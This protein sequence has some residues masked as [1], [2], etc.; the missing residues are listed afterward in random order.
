MSGVTK[1]PKCGKYLCGITV[2]VKEEGT[3]KEL[4]SNPSCT[5][6]KEINLDNLSRINQLEDILRKIIDTRYENDK[7]YIYIERAKKLLKEEK[8]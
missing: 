4:K 5:S 7:L 2:Y 8:G 1:C 3:L 6:E